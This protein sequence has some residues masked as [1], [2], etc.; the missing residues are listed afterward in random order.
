MRHNLDVIHVERNVGAS[1]VS[2][3]LHCGKSKDG[4]NA[5]KDLQDLGV[6]KD[7]HP[8]A[9]GKR[10]YLPAAPWS[11]SKSERKHSASV[12]LSLK[13]LMGI[14]LIYQGV[15]KENMK[16]KLMD[17]TGKK[18]VVAEGRWA[19]N[20]PKQKVHFVP[21]G[22]NVVKVWVDIVKVSDVKVWR[23]SDEVEIMEDALGTAIAWPE[24]KVIMS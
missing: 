2:T 16:C 14:V 22:D 10:T 18:R 17:I 19:T 3:L 7:L 20:D 4:L 1:I 15:S 6:R 5:R 12:C 13:V 9:Q 23:P 24:D 8:N 21:L 11:L